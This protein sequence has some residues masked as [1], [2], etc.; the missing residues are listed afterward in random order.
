MNLCHIWAWCATTNSSPGLCFVF[1][2][3]KL[4]VLDMYPNR[5][6]EVEIGIIM[7][8]P[9]MPEESESN[10]WNPQTEMNG[11]T[12]WSCLLKNRHQGLSRATNHSHQVANCCNRVQI[13][14]VITKVCFLPPSGNLVHKARTNSWTE[15]LVEIF[16]SGINS[17][18]DPIFNNFLKRCGKTQLKSMETEAMVVVASWCL[19]CVIGS[20]SKFSF[21][22]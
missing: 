3:V 14:L 19:I 21:Q 2:P 6:Y 13:V 4:S 17:S 16:G 10:V 9:S 1:V 15:R 8:N 22:F 20:H 12:G 7:A 18:V 5:C 11:R